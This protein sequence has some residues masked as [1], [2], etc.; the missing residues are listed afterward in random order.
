MIEYEKILLPISVGGKPMSK[1]FLIS[2][3]I[4]VPD[5]L[6][7]DEVTDAFI[8]FVESKGWFFGGGINEYTPE[9]KNEKD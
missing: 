6:T 8:E 3:C 9:R 4:E 1:E 2:G 7:R 5:G